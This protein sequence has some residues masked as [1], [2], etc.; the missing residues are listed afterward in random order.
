MQFAGRDSLKVRYTYDTF[1]RVLSQKDARNH[2][3]YYHDDPNFGNLDSTLTPGNRASIVRFDQYGRDSLSKSVGKPWSSVIYDAVNRPTIVNNGVQPNTVLAYDALNLTS[4]TDAKSQVY[5]YEYNA[6]GLVTRLIDPML[7]PDSLAYNAEGLL[8]TRRNRRGQAVL[9][10]YDTLHRVLSKGG[11]NTSL[12]SLGYSRDGR[13]S[14][15]WNTVSRDS[16]F[17]SPSGWVDSVVTSIAGKRFRQQFTKSPRAWLLDSARTASINT[18]IVF[19]KRGFTRD[20]ATLRVIASREEGAW[21]SFA[22]NADG[23]RDTTSYK[24]GGGLPA[25]FKRTDSHTAIHQTYRQQFTSATLNPAF[26]RGYGYD[27]LARI[28]EDRDVSTT[29]KPAQ[30]FGY[31][32]VGQLIGVDSVSTSSSALSD[33]LGG[34]QGTYDPASAEITYAYDNV[35]NRTSSSGTYGTGNRISTFGGVTYVTDVEGNVT[36]KGSTRY[37]WSA[38]G[39]LDS[40]SAG[41]VTLRYRYNVAGQLVEKSRN[42]TVERILL[43][44]GPNLLAE[45]NGTATARIAEYGYDGLDQPM[46]LITGGTTIALARFF[47]QNE[48]GNVTGVIQDSLTIAQHVKY[49]PWGKQMSVTGTLNDTTRLRWKGL[50]WEGDST[51]LYYVRTRWYD[52]ETGRFMTEDP[53]GLAGGINMYAFAGNDPVNGSD[54][55]GL[56]DCRISLTNPC[57]IAGSTTTAECDDECRDARRAIADYG[58]NAGTFQP[59]SP[60]MVGGGGGS[61]GGSG[62]GAAGAPSEDKGAKVARCVL[63]KLKKQAIEVAIGTAAMAA[64]VMGPVVAQPDYSGYVIIGVGRQIAP[65]AA[66]AIT[67]SR[68]FVAVAG[69]FSSSAIGIST[70]SVGGAALV[71]DVAILTA[72]CISEVY[73]K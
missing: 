32:S 10:T 38:E 19:A 48:A 26:S 29:G 16:T 3:V 65:A 20:S 51:K 44:Q 25:N 13:I 64:Y 42:G 61:G 15:G 53:I 2:I 50:V 7:Q 34:Y 49:D 59:T 24:F 14:V 35:G 70:V 71:I 22:A 36:Q 73:G 23:R 40:V 41:T 62:G 37:F 5:R 63:S 43:W 1:G 54:P 60:G 66:T 67:A 11:T 69:A 8:T 58:D 17:R 55:F 21:Q 6:L 30:R 52:P 27:S 4:V 46:A 39:L 56:D 18:S 68:I 47:V 28:R 57:P 72:D 12:D 33:S 45:L 9:L 31:D